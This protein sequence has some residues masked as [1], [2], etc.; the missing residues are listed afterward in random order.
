MWQGRAHAQRT[1]HYSYE[2]NAQLHGHS[3]KPNRLLML[4]VGAAVNYLQLLTYNPLFLLLLLLLPL[5]RPG[6]V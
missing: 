3:H 2:C 4:L 6:A 5:P 1:E